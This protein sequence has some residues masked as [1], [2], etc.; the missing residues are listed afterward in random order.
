ML[1]LAVRRDHDGNYDVLKMPDGRS[2]AWDLD[3][4]TAASVIEHVEN[5]QLKIHGQSYWKL[6]YRRGQRQAFLQARSI[7]Y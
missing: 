6:S 4:A 5:T 2:Y 3:E 1:W 7:R